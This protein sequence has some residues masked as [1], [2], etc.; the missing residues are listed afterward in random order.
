MALNSNGSKQRDRCR[1]DQRPGVIRSGAEVVS[2]ARTPKT[3]YNPV[4]RI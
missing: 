2:K 3:L 4:T 1:C